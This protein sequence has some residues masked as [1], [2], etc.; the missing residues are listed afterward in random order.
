MLVPT[1]QLL[2]MNSIISLMDVS[3]YERVSKGGMSQKKILV[4][5]ESQSDN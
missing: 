2:D 4:I 5:L 1:S 3:E